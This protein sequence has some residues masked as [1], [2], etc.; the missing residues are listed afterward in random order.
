MKRFFSSFRSAC[1]WFLDAL[2]PFSC[3]V[4]GKE[5]DCLCKTHTTFVP[6][7]PNKAQFLFLDDIFV[8]T[9][10]EHPLSKKV[11][12]SLKFKGIRRFS[13]IMGNLCANEI[14]K[15]NFSD[16]VL[17]P[18]P[19]HWMRRFWRGFNQ[20]ELLAREIKLHLPHATLVPLLKRIKRTQQQARLRKEDRNKNTSDAFVWNEKT[21]FEQKNCSV[22][23]I[24]DVVASGATLDACAK[25][26]K[27]H[28][29]LQV[30]AIVFARGGDF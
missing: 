29:V 9:A 16:I 12:E 5:G 25:I 22:F 18:V 10:Y 6:A 28:G 1:R 24:D 11:V 8:C 3:L 4:C 26:L 21:N 19:L 27:Q 17:V 14:V 2:F 13:V 23:L 20:S 15:Q 7:P 30:F